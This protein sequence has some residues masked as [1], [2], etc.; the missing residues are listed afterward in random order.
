MKFKGAGLVWNPE[1]NTLLGKFEDG[2]LET[3]D[4]KEQ[5]LLK[6]LGFEVCEGEEKEVEEEIEGGEGEGK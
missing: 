5:K 4:K 6:K 2:V 1:T 3:K